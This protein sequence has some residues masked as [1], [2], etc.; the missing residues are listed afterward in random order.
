[1]ALSKGQL[2]QHCGKK[3][4]E[5]RLHDTGLLA[6]MSVLTD[7]QSLPSDT[8]PVR[9]ISPCCLA[10]PNNPD[11]LT[12]LHTVIACYR[13]AVLYPRQLTVFDFVPAAHCLS[14]CKRCINHCPLARDAG[15]TSA[16]NLLITSYLSSNV[17]FSCRSSNLCSGTSTCLVMLIRSSAS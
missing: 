16:T 6:L 5:K 3:I 2:V 14:P 4:G 13:I 11:Y 15:D 7:C 17:F 8:Q 1:M 12:S 9:H 10:G